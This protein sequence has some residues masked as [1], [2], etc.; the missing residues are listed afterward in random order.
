MNLYWVT[1]N[2]HSEDWFIVA[3]NEQE[4]TKYHEAKDTK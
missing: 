3:N 1:T 2:D 4:A